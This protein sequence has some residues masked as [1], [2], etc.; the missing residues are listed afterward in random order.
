MPEQ[1][2]SILL[3]QDRKSINILFFNFGRIS[4][5]RKYKKT[6]DRFLK[7][8]MEPQTVVG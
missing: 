6:M 2:E 3:N 4:D 5:C 8:D 1:L 7:N